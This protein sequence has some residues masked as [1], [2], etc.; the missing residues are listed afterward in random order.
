M[1]VLIKPT[2]EALADVT[3]EDEACANCYRGNGSVARL[4]PIRAESGG[5]R[6]RSWEVGLLAIKAD[7]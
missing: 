5:M 6:V 3:H 1:L 7:L 2:A 4:L